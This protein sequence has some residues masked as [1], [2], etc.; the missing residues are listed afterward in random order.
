MFIGEMN[1]H[2]LMRVMLEE[3]NGQRQGAVVPFVTDSTL[4]LGSNRAAFAPDGTL[5]IGHTD[6]GWLGDKGIQRIVWD[7]R[8]PMDVLKMSLTAHGFELTFT[9][10]VEK[11]A[12]SDPGAYQFKR[13]SYEY[14]LDYGSDRMD[15]QPVAVKSVTLS[16]DGRR[17]TVVLPEIE[18]GYVYQLDLN[19]IAASD[20]TPLANSTLYYTVDQL[21]PVP[22]APPFGA[23]SD[24]LTRR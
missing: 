10:P 19:G 6:H 15:E 1:H 23:A 5:W 21:R 11:R 12:A 16:D 17:A 7:G 14:H 3:V 18:R 20:G 24:A 22:P 8:M 13:Y 9:R 2:L 4:K